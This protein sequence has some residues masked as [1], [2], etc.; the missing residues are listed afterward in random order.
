MTVRDGA[1]GRRLLI[2]GTVASQWRPGQVTT[3]S[4]W[5]ALAAPLLLLPRH[6]RRSVAILGLGGGSAARLIRAL[7]PEVHIVGVERDDAV[8]QA[9]RQSFDLAAL[10]VEVHH[11]DAQDWLEY[12]RRQFDLI[13]DDLFT[14][15]ARRALKPEWMVTRGFPLAVRRLASGGVLVSNSIEE[16]VPV[17]HR[18]RTLRPRLVELQ[19]DGFE[20]R[21][22]A[23][24]SRRFDAHSLRRAIARERLLR[25]TLQ[26]IKARTWGLT[27]RDPVGSQI[28]IPI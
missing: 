6:R 18:L 11:R 7:A 10:R 22:F 25:R 23:A 2:D 24:S 16:A 26:K 19:I 28:P 9:A 21:I 12:E 13:I 14:V 3:Q 1:R 27:P 17:A 5:D 20:N 8:L 4:V 15:R